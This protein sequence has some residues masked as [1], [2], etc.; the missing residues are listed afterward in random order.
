MKRT[1]SIHTGGGASLDQQRSERKIRQATE[2]FFTKKKGG[3]PP[4]AGVSEKGHPSDAELLILGI[5]RLV[6]LAL[7]TKEPASRLAG[8]I[9]AHV[10]ALI[11]ADREKLCEANE[12]YRL[13]R[14]KLG[15]AL[16]NDV[17][18]PKSPLYMALHRELWHCRFY[19]GEHQDPLVK[20]KWGAEE[21]EC[22]MKL[23]PL[24]PESLTRWEKE[25]WKLVKKHNPNLPA[26]LQ[27]RYKRVEPRW[28]KNRKE[29]NQH[30]HTLVEASVP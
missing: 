11:A 12:A 18:F 16:R 24:S 27:R 5:K 6:V 19:R 8:K 26:E 22:I 20:P 10:D 13:E 4:K 25:L 29:F 7:N 17:W 3:V 2:K 28:S 15:K 30:L 21:Y 14:P 23:P 1:S 9:L